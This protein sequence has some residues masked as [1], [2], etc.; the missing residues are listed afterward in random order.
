VTKQSRTS[1]GMPTSSTITTGVE[2]LHI[3]CIKLPLYKI[4]FE[5]CYAATVNTII[6]ALFLMN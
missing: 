2:K 6:R 1:T 3:S 5:A 4:K